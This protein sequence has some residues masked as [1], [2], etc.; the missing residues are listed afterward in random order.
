MLE[1]HKNTRPRTIE[2]HLSFYFI[3]FAASLN[4][5]VLQTHEINH[6][7]I[8]RNHFRNYKSK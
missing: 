2:F 4:R 1:A 7:Q 6:I 3:S 5:N 8:T